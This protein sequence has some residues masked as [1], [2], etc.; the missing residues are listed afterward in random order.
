MEHFFKRLPGQLFILSTNEEITSRY[1]SALR[2][3]T[4]NMFLLE[5]GEDKSARVVNNRYFEVE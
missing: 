2:D 1:M 3:R 5:Y 4:S